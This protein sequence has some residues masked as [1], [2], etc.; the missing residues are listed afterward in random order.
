VY[1][2]VIKQLEKKQ[3]E[4]DVFWK[5]VLEEQRASDIPKQRTRDESL[6]NKGGFDST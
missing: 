2:R 6:S 5:K 1:D 4:D 3:A